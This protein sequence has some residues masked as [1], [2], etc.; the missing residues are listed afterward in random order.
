MDPYIYYSILTKLKVLGLP[1]NSSLDVWSVACTLY[2]LYTGRFLFPGRSNNQMLKLMMDLKGKF[3]NKVLR[4]GQFTY[5][6]F[7][8]DLNFM[9]VEVDKVTGKVC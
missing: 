6:H 8:V 2:E 7:D 9:Q 5:K 4:K 1:Y 3:P